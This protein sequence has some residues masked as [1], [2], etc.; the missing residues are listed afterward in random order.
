MP[1]D[2]PAPRVSPTPLRRRLECSYKISAADGRKL[3]DVE[4][5]EVQVR[6]EAD[7][8]DCGARNEAFIVIERGWACRYRITA[9][10]TRQILNFLLPGD[11]VNPDAVAVARTDHG[12][13]SLTDVTYRS[14]ERESMARLLLESPALIAALWWSNAQEKGM[15]QAQIVRLGRQS[16]IQ[17]VGSILMELHRR[18]RLVREIDAEDTSFLLPLTQKD[19]ADALGLS[20][21]H[22]SRVLTELRKA[23]LIRRSADRIELL[24]PKELAAMSDFDLRHLHLDSSLVDSLWG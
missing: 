13:R 1:L 5:S 20:S 12:I 14:I 6:R 10:R 16:A 23:R 24:N 4:H 22:V 19:V 2:S 7:I 11:I 21:V 8:L 17:R 9:A 18:L 3:D 15:L